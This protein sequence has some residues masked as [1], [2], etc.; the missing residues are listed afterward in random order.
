MPSAALFS[1]TMSVKLG[2]VVEDS[3]MPSPADFWIV[4]PDPA[5]PVPVTVRPPEVPV[6]LS[7]MPG[8]APL[9]ETLWNVRPPEPIV[10]LST[11]TR[12]GGTLW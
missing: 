7:R 11:S 3:M 8:L 9:D 12:G 2:A 1:I 5:E 6:L 10:V 4:P